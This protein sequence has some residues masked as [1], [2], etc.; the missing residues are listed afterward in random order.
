MSCHTAWTKRFALPIAFGMAPTAIHSR[1][2]T[3]CPPAMVLR[4]R[5]KD[6]AAP[7]S[8]AQFVRHPRNAFASIRLH[9]LP[10][11]NEHR[12][13]F[14]VVATSIIAIAVLILLMA[15]FSPTAGTHS[16]TT[17][18]P[19]AVV[20]GVSFYTVTSSIFHL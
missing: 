16:Q 12:S 2:A 17:M 9:E 6:V 11:H 5:V 15:A 10:R 7:K 4:Y 8:R 19:R 13:A 3:R 14:A 1:R 18:S 20:C